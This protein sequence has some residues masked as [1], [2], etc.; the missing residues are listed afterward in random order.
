MASVFGILSSTI[1]AGSSA[2]YFGQMTQHLES[3]ATKAQ[4]KSADHYQARVNA[5]YQQIGKWSNLD[6]DIE[7]AEDTLKSVVSRIKS[8]ISRVDSL[9]RIVNQAE[10]DTDPSAYATTFNSLLRGLVNSATDNNLDTDLIGKTEGVSLSFPMSSRSSA[11]FSVTGSYLGSDWTI[12]EA[13]GEVWIPDRKAKSIVRYTDYPETRAGQSANINDG[14]VLDSLVGSDITFTY[15]SNTASPTQYT[16]T[17]TSNGIGITEAWLYEGLT[18]TTGRDNAKSALETATTF[19]ESEM[20]RYQT[21][22]EVAQFYRDRAKA[23]MADLRTD[24]AGYMEESQ[25]ESAKIQEDAQRRASNASLVMQSAM[26]MNAETLR[27]VTLATAASA[28]DLS[29]GSGT[30]LDILT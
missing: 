7:G 10:S 19:L 20:S 16:G 5:A 8:M 14:L 25:S 23:Y 26:M 3:Q 13:G 9:A 1:S 28:K 17:L 6:S 27:M 30:I 11:T 12:Q 21:A 18:T 2:N 22:V 15:G 4:K 24:I 29:G